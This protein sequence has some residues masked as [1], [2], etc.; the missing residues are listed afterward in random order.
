MLEELDDVTCPEC[1]S[2]DIDHTPKQGGR[3]KHKCNDCDHRPWHE[4]HDLEI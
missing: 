3:V 1:G 2:N 4:E